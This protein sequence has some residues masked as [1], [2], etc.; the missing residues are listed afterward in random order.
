MG[1]CTEITK[2]KP[3]LLTDVDMILDYKNDIRRGIAR[4]ICHYTEANSE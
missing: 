1:T 4:V 2:I 3:E